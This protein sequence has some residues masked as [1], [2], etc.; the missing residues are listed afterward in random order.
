MTDTILYNKHN[1]ITDYIYIWVT[2]RLYYEE[3]II[4][5][6]YYLVNI[7]YAAITLRC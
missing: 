7:L 3:Q 4:W 5:L 2:C 1:S 6:I